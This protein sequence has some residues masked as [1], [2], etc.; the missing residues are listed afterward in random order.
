MTTISGVDSNIQKHLRDGNIQLLAEL[1][2]DETQ[3]HT[4]KDLLTQ[5]YKRMSRERQFTWKDVATNM[6]YATSLFLV[7]H[8]VY[9]YKD[10]RFWQ[11]LDIP[12][13]QQAAISEKFQAT[14]KQFGL[15][16]FK[17]VVLKDNALTNI[18]PILLHAGIPRA[19]IDDYCMHFLMR[20]L[21]QGRHYTDI[22]EY[23]DNWLALNLPMVAEPVKR[24]IKYGGSFARDWIVRTVEMAQILH[25]YDRK[26]KQITAYPTHLSSQLHVAEWISHHFWQMLIELRVKSVRTHAESDIEYSRP[27][28]Y[29]TINDEVLIELPRQILLQKPNAT[30][31]WRVI[32]KS[33]Q[34]HIAPIVRTSGRYL[35]VDARHM[36]LKR[37]QELF[38]LRIELHYGT[39]CEISWDFVRDVYVFRQYNFTNRLMLHESDFAKIEFPNQPVY[40]LTAKKHVILADNSEVYPS[41]VDEKVWLYKLNIPEIQSINIDSMPLQIKEEDINLYACLVAGQQLPF[42]QD[43]GMD[44][45]YA[46]LPQIL[47]PWSRNMKKPDQV[48][49][50]LLTITHQ[51][52]NQQVLLRATL[53]NLVGVESAQDGIRVDLSRCVTNLMPGMYQISL[54]SQSGRL[55]VPQLSFIYVPTLK[56]VYQTP[57]AFPAA[58]KYV[59][60]EVHLASVPEDWQIEHATRDVGANKWRCPIVPVDNRATITFIH[61]SDPDQR[62]DIKLTIPQL[63][64]VYRHRRD[65][66]VGQNCYMSQDMSWY[67]D[68]QP[69]IEL[70]ISPESLAHMRDFTLAIETEI[71]SDNVAP[72]RL[73]AHMDAK[74]LWFSFDTRQIIDTI[75]RAPSNVNF[76]LVVQ[77]IDGANTHVD[78]LSLQKPV[79][80]VNM[81]IEIKSVIQRWRIATTWSTPHSQASW[82]LVVWS[83][84]QPWQEPE[85]KNVAHDV[86]ESSSIIESGKLFPGYEYAIGFMSVGGDTHRIPDQPPSAPGIKRVLFSGDLNEPKMVEA[87]QFL[88]QKIQSSTSIAQGEIT[89]ERVRIEEITK[90]LL[91]LYGLRL[92][93]VN[94]QVLFDTL[95]FKQHALSKIANFK[96]LELLI[97][98][99]LVRTRVCRKD[100]PD[101][102]LFESLM[103]D[104]SSRIGELLLKYEVNNALWDVHIATYLER[105]LTS[106]DYAVLRRFNIA[107]Q[108]SYQ[109]LFFASIVHQAQFL[110]MPAVLCAVPFIFD[111]AYEDVLIVT[112]QFDGAVHAWKQA[113]VEQHRKALMSTFLLWLANEYYIKK[114]EVDVRLWNDDE[115]IPLLCN[116]LNQYTVDMGD[117][118]DYLLSKYEQNQLYTPVKQGRQPRTQRK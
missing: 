97:A 77:S 85:I 75:R 2:E 60:P 26:N 48:N 83:I 12:N 36:P 118:R 91:Y 19:C 25:D 101:F 34:Y 54:R 109:G 50:W 51:T 72:M 70:Q 93:L 74:K 40:L 62:F 55:F 106:T 107:Y 44:P 92:Y 113:R 65:N 3:Y 5:Y 96:P 67:E 99:L 52:T 45:V 9:G 59:L 6:P 33:D 105:P 112:G 98:T 53:H 68:V 102:A 111:I 35:H 15:P 63:D 46:A 58:I 61:R 22:N 87:L 114:K 37:A 86:I 84:T 21:R 117:L 8:G 11:P 42:V 89:S 31:V 10:N 80:V 100:N 56:L 116:Y 78:L 16:T 82:K 79:N 57:A 7:L 38:T 20:Y 29:W 104:I 18:T 81:Q 95:L 32:V 110:R 41:E 88:F 23:I 24:F 17:S 108:I 73:K 69:S 4:I 30:V 28:V 49:D 39:E 103:N 14:L 1:V 27:Q 66:I 90:L 71:E 64:I 43:E 47:I 13:Q 76:R 94:D 115:V